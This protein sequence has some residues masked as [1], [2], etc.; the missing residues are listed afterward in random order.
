[1]VECGS[2]AARCDSGSIGCGGDAGSGYDWCGGH[3]GYCSSCDCCGDETGGA[4]GEMILI[5]L[6]NGCDC[7]DA[8]DDGG[9]YII[10]IHVFA[11]IDVV[12]DDVGGAMERLVILVMVEW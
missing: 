4:Y 2:D 6:A 8:C 12:W 7:I 1:M 3:T 5:T 10:I 11:D 9:V